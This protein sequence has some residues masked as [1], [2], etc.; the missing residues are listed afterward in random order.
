VNAREYYLDI[1]ATIHAAPHVLRSEMSFEEIDITECYIRGT[2]HLLGDLELHVAEYVVTEPGI[3]R[4][5]YRY[6]LQ[7]SEN[8]AL[9]SRWDNVAHYP[10][11]PT[12]PHH[13]HNS[14]GLVQ[15]A[16]PMDVVKLLDA[17][18]EFIPANR[19]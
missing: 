1:Q 5:K 12:F 19:G 17:V 9:I 18:L 4:L 6:H 3:Q 8:K 10:Q 13:R 14:R 2:L 11:L 15:P 16:E 7:A